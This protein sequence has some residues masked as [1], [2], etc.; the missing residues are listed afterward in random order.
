MGADSPIE[1]ETF[2]NPFEVTTDSNANS[3]KK[4][5]QGST[6]SGVKLFQQA[7]D[8]TTQAAQNA[9]ENL[10]QAMKSA[11]E[12][13]NI[14]NQDEEGEQSYFELEN[15][16]GQNENLELNSNS[17]VSEEVTELMKKQFK[18]RQDKLL[19]EITLNNLKKDDHETAKDSNFNKSIEAKR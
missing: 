13:Y 2:Q 3:G 8:A 9:I 5:V 11:R 19:N 18:E 15:D 6:H 7:K 1:H 16:T 14:I 12:S 4:S 17:A 10:Q